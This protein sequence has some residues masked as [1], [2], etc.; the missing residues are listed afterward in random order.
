MCHEVPE[1]TPF[2]VCGRLER[3]LHNTVIWNVSI[4]ASQIDIWRIRFVVAVIRRS[5][6]IFAVRDECIFQTYG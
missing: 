4:R 6:Y 3:E 2:H 1:S 5:A